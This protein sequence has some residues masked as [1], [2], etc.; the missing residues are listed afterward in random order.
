MLTTLWRAWG[1]S[2]DA[3]DFVC[4]WR[5]EFKGCFY[6]SDYDE[7]QK[8]SSIRVACTLVSGL[9]TCIFYTC[10]ILSDIFSFINIKFYIFSRCTKYLEHM[11]SL[12]II[13]NV[14]DNYEYHV[15]CAYC[16]CPEKLKW[17]KI[18]I[19]SMLIMQIICNKLIFDFWIKSPFTSKIVSL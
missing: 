4:S 11:G 15:F 13:K 3:L 7:K 12:H 9:T 14:Y 10:L 19:I 8:L 1:G 6:N 2:V 17:I 18:R 16:R 5:H